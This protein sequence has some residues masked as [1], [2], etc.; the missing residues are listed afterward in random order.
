[1][2]K[3]NK[4]FHLEITVEQFLNACSLLELQEVDLLIGDYLKRAEHA[5]VVNAYRMGRIAGTE[6]QEKLDKHLKG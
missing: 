4:S 3:L 2:P 6:V 5:S 1:M